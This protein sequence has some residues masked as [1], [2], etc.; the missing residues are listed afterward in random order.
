M[1]PGAGC[2]DIVSQID[3]LIATS[4]VIRTATRTYLSVV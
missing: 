1:N 2:R 3:A 4:S